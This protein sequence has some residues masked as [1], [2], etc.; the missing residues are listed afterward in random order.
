MENRYT[1]RELQIKFTSTFTTESPDDRK[2]PG[3]SLSGFF[4]FALI[5]ITLIFFSNTLV[6]AEDE[7]TDNNLYVQ[8]HV[9]Y[10]KAYDVLDRINAERSKR[11]IRTLP[12]DQT[13]MDAAYV[14]AAETIVYF[15]H[16]RP[17]GMVWHSVDDKVT[18]ENLGMGTGSAAEIMKLWME[19]PG[20]K[21]NILRPE[22]AS[23]GVACIE[24]RDIHYWVQLFGDTGSEGAER[25]QN[26]TKSLPLDLPREEDGGDFAYDYSITVNGMAEDVAE[27]DDGEDYSLGLRAENIYFDP[28]KLNWKIDDEDI[29]EIDKNGILSIKEKGETEITALSGSIE[30]ASVSI[31]SRENVKDLYIMDKFNFSENISPRNRIDG[32]SP[33]PDLIVLSNEGLLAEGT[34]YII[35]Y[36]DANEDGEATAEIIGVGGYKG[37]VIKNYTVS[38]FSASEQ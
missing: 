11:G 29:A 34:D 31:D 14:R 22:F 8:V 25:P 12:M 9:D 17:N 2:S 7:E 35:S 23:V 27:A 19:S 3:L 6:Y 26:E 33:R 1:Q 38:E 37:M 16:A 13:L 20:H 30:R 10:D 24:Y 15:E 36:K 4:I 18:G 5:T 21:E 28:S 32:E